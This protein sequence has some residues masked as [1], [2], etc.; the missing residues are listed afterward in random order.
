MD[1]AI[2]DLLFWMDMAESLVVQQVVQANKERLLE[3][4]EVAEHTNIVEDPIDIHH[5]NHL[6]FKYEIYITTKQSEVINAKITSK[7]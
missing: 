2:I 5:L 6:L 1:A 3:A 7:A 4:A